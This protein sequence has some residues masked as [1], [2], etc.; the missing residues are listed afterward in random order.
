MWNWRGGG[1][2]GRARYNRLVIQTGRR[3][4]FEKK[5][6]T[7]SAAPLFFRCSHSP[8]GPLLHFHGP[9]SRVNHGPA[10]PFLSVDCF[11]SSGSGNKLSGFS[12]FFLFSLLSLLF[13][14]SW[15]SPSIHTSIPSPFPQPTLTAQHIHRMTS[16]RSSM[17]MTLLALLLCATVQAQTLYSPYSP[18]SSVVNCT[19][20][21]A[22]CRTLTD[23]VY[24]N[25][26]KYGLFFF[27]SPCFA[28]HFTF[29]FFFFNET[30]EWTIPQWMNNIDSG[31][32]SFFS[33]VFNL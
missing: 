9:C 31:R 3:S 1:I 14:F 26:K 33:F 24:G 6:S 28:S 12:F 5:L 2:N 7:T 23:S 4:Q 11:Y 10:V 25:G 13:L 18:G 8:L 16:A 15:H 22:N 32:F 30:N 27:C 29:F 20:W 21:I 17:M 19:A